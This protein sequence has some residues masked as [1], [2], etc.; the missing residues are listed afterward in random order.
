[1][2]LDNSSDESKP[3]HRQLLLWHDADKPEEGTGGAK[4][5]SG[6]SPGNLDDGGSLDSPPANCSSAFLDLFPRDNT[7]SGWTVDPNNLSTVGRVAA[8]ATTELGAENLIDGA[9]SAFFTAPYSP[10]TFAWQ[11]YVSTSV[12]DAPAPN[13]ATVSLYM[14]QM[15]TAEQAS[16]LYASLMADPVYS[17]RTWID[18]SSPLIGTDSRIADTGSC[19]WINFYKGNCY[20]EV[21]LSPSYGPAPNY[22]PGDPNTKAAAMTFSQAVASRM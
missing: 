19:W 18:P 3:V 15:A 17:G 22:S 4:A 21:S 1:V 16:G 8:T 9:S 5:G 12:T 14:L 10:Q 11:N 7:I 13:Y 6:G 2:Y 20:A